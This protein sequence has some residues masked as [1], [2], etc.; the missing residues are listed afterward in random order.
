L[1]VA[2]DYLDRLTERRYL[3]SAE[4]GRILSS[5]KIVDMWAGGEKRPVETLSGGEQFLASLSL[6][7]AL[8]ELSSTRGEVGSLFLDEGFGTLDSRSLEMVL[9]ALERLRYEGRM[10]GVISHLDEVKRRI[11][12]KVLVRKSSRGSSIHIHPP[13]GK[14]GVGEGRMST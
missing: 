8:S 6:A 1:E 4:E 9:D 10:I 11:P 14:F 5:L 3:F 12:V 13:S 7:L 2:N